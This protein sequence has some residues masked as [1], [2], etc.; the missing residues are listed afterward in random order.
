ML[1]SSKK[2][3]DQVNFNISICP[4]C[5]HELIYIFGDQRGG[6]V[7]VRGGPQKHLNCKQA[8]RQVPSN[9]PSYSTDNADHLI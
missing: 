4:L 7:E 6:E 1:L 2:G 9:C 8:A 5:P 3:E